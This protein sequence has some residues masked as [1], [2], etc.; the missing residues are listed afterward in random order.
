MDGLENQF[1]VV[2]LFLPWMLMQRQLGNN[3]KKK[4]SEELRSVPLI[5]PSARLLNSNCK[6]GQIFLATRSIASRYNL[7]KDAISPDKSGREVALLFGLEGSD[8]RLAGV[9]D[10]GWA[11]VWR[12]GSRLALK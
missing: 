8:D 2:F 10:L 5:T 9:L 4:L 1:L 3:N 12:R 11:G 7:C 6:F